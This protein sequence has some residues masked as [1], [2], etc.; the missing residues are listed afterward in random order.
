MGE[1]GD[2]F[3]KAREA[4]ELSLDDVSNVTKISPRMLQ[5]IEEQ[6]FDRLPGG[7]FNKGFIRAYAKHLGLNAEDAITEYLECLR[8]AQV[9]AQQAW[10]P[11]LPDKGK[12]GSP[13]KPS[14][15]EPDKL[16]A[17]R[18]GKPAAFKQRPVDIPA[19]VPAN[20]PAKPAAISAAKTASRSAAPAVSDE[21][22]DLQLPREAD[23]HTGEGS[24]PSPSTGIQWR[25]IAVAAII[26]IIAALLWTR[27]GNE[28]TRAANRDVP[29]STPSTAPAPIAP[30]ANKVVAGPSPTAVPSASLQSSAPNLQPSTANHAA[31]PATVDANAAGQAGSSE[32]TPAV[33]TEDRNDVTVRTFGKPA[34]AKPAQ[35]AA[36]TFTVVVRAAENSWISVS[37]DGQLITQ[38]TLIAPAHTSFHASREIVVKVGNAGGVSFAFNG[39]EIPPQGNEAEPRTLVF[40]SSGLKTSPAASPAITN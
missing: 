29:V 19:D 15:S 30:G 24:Q 40:D 13:A 5:A 12:P 32:S 22:P 28:T 9:A 18:P 8:Q 14:P 20:V 26:G 2:K 27:R 17:E 3:R 38:E 7:V 4:K 39:T 11:Q 36:G 6:N 25:L 34:Q 31:S 35:P 10:E 1:F 33:T 37:A 21:L 23:I 16:V